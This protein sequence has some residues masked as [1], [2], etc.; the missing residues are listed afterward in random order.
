MYKITR[1]SLQV[2]AMLTK[3]WHWG[4]FI[5]LYCMLLNGLIQCNFD[6]LSQVLT[7]QRM[8]VDFP[9]PGL[10]T[11]RTL[12]FNKGFLTHRET[13]EAQRIMGDQQMLLDREFQGRQFRHAVRNVVGLIFYRIDETSEAI[14]HFKQT[15]EEDQSNL[16]ALQDLV[17]CY[18]KI[19][20]KQQAK[21][22][23]DLF[24]EAKEQCE[25]RTKEERYARCQAEQA[26]ALF[27]DLRKKFW[28]C[29]DIR[30]KKVKAFEDALCLGKDEISRAERRDW[31]LYKGA[32][33]EKLAHAQFREMK[34]D[35]YCLS[36]KQTFIVL[37]EC[38]IPPTD[39]MHEA[40][41]WCTLGNAFTQS[42]KHQTLVNLLIEKLPGADNKMKERLKKPHLCYEKAIECD[43]DNEIWIRARL[44]YHL[45]KNEESRDKSLEELNLSISLAEKLTPGNPMKKACRLAYPT[46]AQAYIWQAQKEKDKNECKTNLTNA[47]EDAKKAVDINN[48]PQALATKGE[49]Y[50]ELAKQEDDGKEI[51][52]LLDDALIT[53]T[54]ALECADGQSIPNTHLKLARCL[55]Y[56]Q[57]YQSAI[58][59]YKVAFSIYKPCPES[60]DHNKRMVGCE[61]L[62]NMF[63]LYVSQNKPE[64]LC[65]DIAYWLECIFQ[66]LKHDEGMMGHLVFRI[67]HDKYSQ[68]LTSVLEFVLHTCRTC[69][70]EMVGGYLKYLKEH[71]LPGET[72]KKVT[73]LI[74]RLKGMTKNEQQQDTYDSKDC[75]LEP[76]GEA[77]NE[78]FKYDF[79]IINDDEPES[80]VK[81]WVEHLLL[82]GLE[83]PLYGL[84]GY[85]HNRERLGLLT[86]TTQGDAMECSAHVIL[87]LSDGFQGSAECQ[88]LANMACTCKEELVI[89]YKDQVQIPQFLTLHNY[90]YIDFSA[91]PNIHELAGYLGASESE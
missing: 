85:Y 59:S 29:S 84:K 5:W 31:Y 16:N 83:C 32:A 13:R 9:T 87:V 51:Q 69:R 24:K 7:S 52:K 71:Y 62:L 61:L 27:C 47:L 75:Y 14:V 79:Y 63:S 22:Y 12:A 44:G 15:V 53:F 39:P 80:N 21:K 2:Q 37:N 10:L 43:S 54:K 66:A 42:F 73:A 11:L 33:L 38:L 1:S 88:T 78:E 46:R 60:F 55:N 57:D 28:V 48:H 40:Q 56:M 26:Y 68:E 58:A 4:V 81:Q 36:L 18:Q 41:V 34:T 74:R 20:N 6:N 76:P 64:N 70:D 35:K 19:K 72:W 50:F 8:A 89:L 86:K 82:P 90:K 67:W 45:L 65:R 91:Q 77:K 3:V 17:T 49:V 25:D 30:D 23:R